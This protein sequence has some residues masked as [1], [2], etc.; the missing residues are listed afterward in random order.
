[1]FLCA[2]GWPGSCLR[3]FHRVVGTM[4]CAQCAVLCPLLPPPPPYPLTIPTWPACPQSAIRGRLS[5]R[6]FALAKKA[7]VKLQAVV[8]MRRAK[9][10]FLQA[11]ASCVL[12]QAGF[13][14]AMA[15][16]DIA[17]Q[18]GNGVE[19]VGCRV[20][21]QPHSWAG[22]RRWGRGRRG[23]AASCACM[24]PVSASVASGG[25]WWGWPH[26]DVSVCA[27]LAVWRAPPSLSLPLSPSLP[28]PTYN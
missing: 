21:A 8:R 1:M 9:R 23:H 5:R 27:H 28:S 4:L 10:E 18:V 26:A 15:R 6:E 20:W 16:G 2:L 11:K 3:C 25:K 24:G 12:I 13:R 14:G 7:A 19:G 17:A 22:G